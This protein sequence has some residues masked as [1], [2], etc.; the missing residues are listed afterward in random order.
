MANQ[1]PTL[2]TGMTNNLVKRVYQHKNE[3]ADGFTKKYHIHKLVYF[4]VFQTAMEA[5]IREKQIK[6]LDRIEKIK[7]I[8]SENPG[9][10]DLYPEIIDS[11]Q[12][13]MTN[14]LEID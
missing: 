9:F 13:R 6:D 4:E 11:G 10:E 2:Y 14:R 1:R 8:E 3:L 7:L 5:I 12:A